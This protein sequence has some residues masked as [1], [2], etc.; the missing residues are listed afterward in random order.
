M[1]GDIL[2]SE[3][4]A[5]LPTALPNSRSADTSPVRRGWMKRGLWKTLLL[6]QDPRHQ[7]WT[8]GRTRKRAVEENSRTSSIKL[9]GHLLAGAG[10]N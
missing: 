1:R 5:V 3:A 8:S 4:M 7:S 10:T 9:P 6:C 2:G